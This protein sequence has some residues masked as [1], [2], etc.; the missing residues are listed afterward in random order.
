MSVMRVGVGEAGTGPVGDIQGARE[1]LSWVAWP[2]TILEKVQAFEGSLIL[3]V[4]QKVADQ[5]V[6]LKGLEGVMGEGG[7]K[8]GFPEKC[9]QNPAQKMESRK[10]F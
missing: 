4:V 5:K 9:N 2:Y 7:L 10:E 1:Q 3:N 6:D 8:R